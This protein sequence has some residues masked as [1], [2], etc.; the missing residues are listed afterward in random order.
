MLNTKKN[1]SGPNSSPGVPMF[2]IQPE[3]IET[4]GEMFTKSAVAF[5]DALF[6]EYQEGRITYPEIESMQ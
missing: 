5:L 1:S 6:G 2:T 3:T 4:H